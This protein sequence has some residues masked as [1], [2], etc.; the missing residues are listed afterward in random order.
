MDLQKILTHTGGSTEDWFKFWPTG[1]LTYF[2]QDRSAAAVY[3]VKF[4]VAVTAGDIACP[5]N[6]REDF[7]RRYFAHCR[8]N[9]WELAFLNSE[10]EF[11]ALYEQL[12]LNVCLIGH[13]AIIDVRNFLDSTQHTGHFK[14]IRNRANRKHWRFTP[15]QPPHDPALLEELTTLA[16]SWAKVHC[17]KERGFL[18]S[19]YSEE[20]IRHSKV[21]CVRDEEGKLGAFLN[22]IPSYRDNVATFDLM[23]RAPSAPNGVMDFLIM[24]YIAEVRARGFDQLSL[25]FSPLNPKQLELTGLLGEVTKKII[26]LKSVT[27]FGSGL[28][29]YKA[30]FE[31]NMEPRYIAYSRGRWPQLKTLLAV[32][33]VMGDI[34]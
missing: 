29:A 22:E 32:R 25:G 2:N 9:G 33:G 20:Y 15:S 4:G 12:G 16:K 7:L 13:N 30:K 8:S 23:R 21:F 1:K 26:N 6:Q 18:N 5:A 3:K 28:S 17:H 11:K 31:P 24:R 27:P 34:S 19:P 10:A 14:T